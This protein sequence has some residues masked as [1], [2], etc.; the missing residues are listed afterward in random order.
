M[1]GQSFIMEWKKLHLT[2]LAFPKTNSSSPSL[3]V[4]GQVIQDPAKHSSAHQEYTHP[5]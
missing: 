5:A 4:S 2:V 3:I 1:E